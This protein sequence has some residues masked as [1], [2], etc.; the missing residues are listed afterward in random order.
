MINRRDFLIRT[1]STAITAGSG[2]LKRLAYAGSNGQ[3]L[4]CD[5]AIIGG[6]VG[7]VAAAVAALRNGL[8]VILTEETDWIGGQLTQQAV[9]PDEHS[10]IEQFGSTRT[11][12]HFRT[13]VRNHYKT[14][15]PLNDTSIRDPYLD[16]GN[17]DVSRICHEPRVALSILESMLAAESSAYNLKI[18]LNTVPK[19]A[20]VNGDSVHS[21]LVQDTQEGTETTI[22]SP[23]FLDATEMGDLLPLTKT[24]YISG[25]ES[26]DQTGEP[27]AADRHDPTNIQSITWCFAMDYREGEDHTIER[28][29]QYDLWKEFIPNLTPEWPGRMLSWTYTNPITLKPATM[30]FDPRRE[31]VN[32][33]FWAYRRLID[34]SN[35]R[36]RNKSGITLVNWPMNDFVGG[37]IFDVP[38]EEA[39][40]NLKNA[41]QQS[42]SLLYWMQ[43]EAP[44]EDGKAGWPGLGLRKD[45]TGTSHGLAKRPYIRESR[46]IKAEFT[47]LE[48]HIGTEARS[49]ISG[50]PEGKVS[51]E[52]FQDSV[53]IGSYRID[54]H[55][56]T[57]G[58]NYIDISSLPFEIPLGSLIPERMENILPASKN[59]G[60]THI[61]NGCYRLHPVEWNIGESVGMLVAFCKKRSLS[62]KQVRKRFIED[63]QSELHRQGVEYRWPDSLRSAQ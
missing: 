46:R 13:S 50:L 28:P 36:D 24:E 1:S 52:K 9:P 54:L 38:K 57:G 4:N 44:R 61:T 32:P 62:P 20:A 14:W 27:H 60:T 47:V 63:F 3:Q 19:A 12:R 43:T 2:I 37:N 33:G 40:K 51:A 29:D 15:Y 10:W 49:I 18:L 35:F 30:G 45:V 22:K 7:G 8:T 42:L 56:S 11:Y 41:K 48:N 26:K 58:D 31:A 55:P 21:I 34:P 17:C 25:A 16:P 23:W 59:I 6:G 53:G 39:A 5:V